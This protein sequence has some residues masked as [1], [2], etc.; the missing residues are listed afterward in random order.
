MMF[1]SDLGTMT[2]NSNCSS[3]ADECSFIQWRVT[4]PYAVLPLGK[5]SCRLLKG[6]STC[7]SLFAPMRNHYWGAGDFQKIEASKFGYKK[8]QN[9]GKYVCD[10]IWTNA[11]RGHKWIILEFLN[12]YIYKQCVWY[13]ELFIF[14]KGGGERMCAH[15][16]S[17]IRVQIWPA[18]NLKSFT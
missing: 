3:D 12:N 18:Q 4:N 6:Q 16:W 13:I 7:I 11:K 9:K 2:L 15:I 1:F 17:N 10:Q 14:M 5:H 8:Q